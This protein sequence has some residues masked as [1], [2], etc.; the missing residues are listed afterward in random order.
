M[1]ILTD[2]KNSILDSFFNE[3]N[4]KKHKNNHMKTTHVR[5]L[6]TQKKTLHTAKFSKKK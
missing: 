1:S 4:K 3:E 2:M 6:K 5:T